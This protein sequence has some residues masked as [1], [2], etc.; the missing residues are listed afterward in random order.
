TSVS[1][2]LAA[3]LEQHMAS[4]QCS[5][6]DVRHCYR[7]ARLALSIAVQVEG[8]KYDL[9]VVYLAGLLHDVL[10]SKL[11][12]SQAT[13]PVSEQVKDLL[14]RCEGVSEERISC[15]MSIVKSV[16]YKNLI[17]PEWASVVAL[18]P[19]EYV[20]V[21]D[22]DLLDAIG[23]IGL[24]RVFS[25]GGRKNRPIF[26]FSEGDALGVNTQLTAEQYAVRAGGSIEHFFDKLLRI[27]L[28]LKTAPGVVLGEKRHFR[29]VL[30]LRDVDEE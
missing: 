18:L 23:S 9:R 10:D 16:G 21:Q 8:E 13:V 22:A 5:A 17:K 11:V 26:G 15:I 30:F 4:F 24:T 28:L 6:H 12:G 1:A 20:A 29:M 27:R 19:R 25:Y 3:F 14:Q 2:E 7:V